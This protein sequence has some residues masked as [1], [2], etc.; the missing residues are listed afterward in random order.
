MKKV[1]VIMLLSFIFTSW[2]SVPSMAAASITAN[3]T[4]TNYTGTYKS[5]TT[6]V[7]IAIQGDHTQKH[8]TT[9]HVYTG[10]TR[11]SGSKSS[12]SISRKVDS[13]YNY[14]KVKFT[15]FKKGTEVGSLTKQP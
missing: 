10:M 9:G 15:A 11:G 12:I 8:K 14:T 6:G 5:G 4:K 2:N 1:I 7:S 13:G 3:V